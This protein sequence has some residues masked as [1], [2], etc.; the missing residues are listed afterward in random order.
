MMNPRPNTRPLPKTRLQLFVT[1]AITMVM[2]VSA[3]A[4]APPQANA[5]RVRPGDIGRI[6]NGVHIENGQYFCGGRLARPVNETDV[7][8][9]TGNDV[10]LAMGDKV[11]T[12]S[13]LAG[14]DIICV[15][16]PGAFIS[17]GAGNDLIFTPDLPADWP[18]HLAPPIATTRGGRGNDIV[19]G[20]SSWDNIAGGAGSDRL[21]GG[22]GY[23]YL[24]GGLGQDSLD[25]GPNGSRAPEGVN[26]PGDICQDWDSDRQLGMISC[27]RGHRD[28]YATVEMPEVPAPGLEA[29]SVPNQRPCGF[30]HFR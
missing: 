19:I 1:L 26:A 8:G 12:V 6:G 29:C 20:G 21:H 5:Q 16:T 25:G 18:P 9:T 27:E 30:S 2:V 22:D 3:L 13:G 24:W 23:D 28:P 4:M 17:G 14:K 15:V 10:I 7:V 11:K